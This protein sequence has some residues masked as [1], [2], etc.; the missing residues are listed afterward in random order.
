MLT[1][2][3]VTVVL[4]FMKILSG[5]RNY[6]MHLLTTDPSLHAVALKF[7][8]L[9]FKTAKAELDLKFLLQCRDNN[10]TPK[11]VHWKNLKSKRRKLRNS[12]HRKILKEAIQ[13]KRFSLKDMKTQLHEQENLITA[14]TSWLKNITLKYHAQRLSDKKLLEVA[15]RHE[16][17]FTSLL[18]EHKILTGLTNNP[19]D[20]IT[21]L[22][23]DTIT[24]EEESILQ[25][26]LKHGLA[27]RPKESDIIATAESIWEQ[28]DREKQLPDG[29]I[30]HQ[31]VK[32]SIKAL[33]CNFLDFDDKC[34]HDD[35]K[36]IK[37][38]KAMNEK[39]AILKPDKGS[40]VALLK[41]EDYMNGMT[42]LFADPYKFRKLDKNDTLT[43]LTTLQSHLRKIHNR[44]EINDDE[45]NSIRPQS[46]KP[47]RA[48]GLPKTHKSYDTL[49]PLRPI[50]DM[51]GNAYQPVA[52][53]LSR[54]LN[55]LTHNEFSLKDSF[56]AVNRIQNIPDNLF[57][58]G[59]RFISFDVKSLF[60]NIP[61]D[62]TVQIVLKKIYDENII[63]TTVK[64]RTLKKL[65]LDACTKTQF[66][67]NGDL[68][69]QIDGVSMGSPLSPTLANI[70]M[71]ALE[72]EIIKD[73]FENETIK[74][75]VRYVDDTLV[76]AKPCDI[77]LILNKLN[78]YHPDIQFTHEQFV[79][80]NEVHFLDIKL[81]S[82][83]TSI[84]RKS[85]HTGQYIHLSSFTQWSF[86]IVWIRSLVHRAYKICSNE[87]LISDEM[88]KIR[89]FMSWNG[90]AKTLANKLIH[91]FTP[92][93]DQAYMSSNINNHIEDQTEQVCKVYVRLPYIGKRGTV[94]MHKF[95][96]KISR[97]LKQPCKFIV[98]WD[99]TTTGCFVSCKD[100]TPK[101]FQSL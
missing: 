72:D 74:F 75:Y 10:I 86:K 65:L 87:S 60:T 16:R 15:K 90:F 7:Q 47:A 61:L 28:L 48:H 89:K 62:K 11:F 98:Y 77:N 22:T 73:L 42:E 100:K 24:K 30:K 88:R 58:D 59:Y 81:T 78:S 4:Y 34:L 20:I 46:T 13:D 3:G 99:T 57:T 29:Y 85:T 31:R 95:K 1:L 93:A 19:N 25:F 2:L 55:P 69:K 68:Y 41:K 37:V 32:H 38:L 79:D 82:N 96:L 5:S 70:I 53:F 54:L 94:L 9:Y 71:I 64:K 33:A 67:A 6:W 27:T 39:Y 66:F 26:G 50:I 43:Q 51:T 14:R 35:H 23:G 52:K 63:T 21:N 76:L 92:K 18:H 56:D 12:Y 80:N 44:G 49:P 17:K 83:G 36:R 91:K 84:F 45:Y 40:G 101:E 8:K 97:I